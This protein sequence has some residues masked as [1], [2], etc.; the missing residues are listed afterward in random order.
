MGT[1]RYPAS[2][3]ADANVESLRPPSCKEVL[4]GYRDGGGNVVISDLQVHMPLCAVLDVFEGCD[5]YQGGGWQHGE[6]YCAVGILKH[7]R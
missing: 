2:A 5:A 3:G 1:E 7:C 4:V 6:I